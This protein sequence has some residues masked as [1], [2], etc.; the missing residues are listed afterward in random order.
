MLQFFLAS[1]RAG[2][3]SRALLGYFVLGLVLVFC[4]YLSASFS[5]RQ[6][7]TVALDVGLSGLRFCLIFI[8][9][10]LVQDLVGREIERRSVLFS[11]SY[12][13]SRAGYLLGRFFGVIALS[14]AAA[15]ILS[16]LLWLAVMLAG[17]TYEQENRVVLGLPYWATIGGLWLDSVVVTSFTLLVCSLATVSILP[18]AAGLSFAVIGKAFGPLVDF[19]ARGA[20]GQTA[21][22]MAYSPMLATAEWLIPDLSRLDWRF[23]PM[24]GVMPELGAIGFSIVMALCYSAAML[25][26]SVWCFSRREF[27]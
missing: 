7:R 4:A 6:L 14:G 15:A 18:L 24:Y 16:M 5:M 3:R 12:P 21:L 11:L 25:A 23:W 20:D 1:W 19:I 22:V 17:G 10:T 2:F 13:C 9:I 26:F 8:S 27:S